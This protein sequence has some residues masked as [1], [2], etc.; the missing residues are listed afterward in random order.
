MIA[1]NVRRNRVKHLINKLLKHFHISQRSG[2]IIL[3]SV[4]SFRHNIEIKDVMHKETQ[5]SAVREILFNFYLD[6]LEFF[7]KAHGLDYN[8]PAVQERASETI[9]R[10][11]HIT[12]CHRQSGIL[13][14]SSKDTVAIG[15][16]IL[17]Y[18]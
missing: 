1:V 18:V 4:S 11:Q 12:R 5:P 17:K 16:L 3:H 2:N 15:N 7:V 13:W 6:N 8:H 14:N 9:N 10:M